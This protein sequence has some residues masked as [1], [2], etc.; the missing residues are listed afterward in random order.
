MS[1]YVKRAD[2]EQAVFGHLDSAGDL[3]LRAVPSADV[4]EADSKTVCHCN[5]KE[6]A[7]IIAKI[8]DADVDGEIADVKLSTAA[9]IRS[10][11]RKTL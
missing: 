1:D 3:R 6:N 9:D 2:V 11:L 7:E 10:Y 5:V 8:L 4:V